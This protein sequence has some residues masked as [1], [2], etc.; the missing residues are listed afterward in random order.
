MPGKK[1]KIKEGL[2]FDSVP[3]A[4]KRLNGGA[5][6]EVLSASNWEEMGA[7]ILTPSQPADAS[8]NAANIKLKPD[9]SF[10][11]RAPE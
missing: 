9:R 4:A 2:E 3:C 1:A 10:M 11:N 5:K 8:T 7:V 6:E